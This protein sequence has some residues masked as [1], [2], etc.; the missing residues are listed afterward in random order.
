MPI[1]S[2]TPE[3]AVSEMRAAGYE[4]EEPWPG[5][6]SAQWKVRCRECGWP[7]AVRLT[8]ARKGIPCSHRAPVGLPEEEVRKELEAA[9]FELLSGYDGHA[10]TILDLRCIECGQVKRRPLSDVRAGKLCGHRPP[11][12]PPTD[13]EGAAEEMRAAGYEPEEPYPGNVDSSWR[14]RCTAKWCR[15]ERRT[16]LKAVREGQRCKHRQKS[17]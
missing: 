15:R 5:R 9:G 14:V 4:P 10:I 16:S 6:A 13:H 3:Q 12:A 11:V 7:R 2:V 17:V 8:Y 1:R